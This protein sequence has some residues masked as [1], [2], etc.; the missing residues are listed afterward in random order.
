MGWLNDYRFLV[1]L[2]TNG[3]DECSAVSAS[4]GKS[5][6]EG[7][8][9]GSHLALCCIREMNHVNSCNDIALVTTLLVEIYSANS[10]PFREMQFTVKVVNI[11]CLCVWLVQRITEGCPTTMSR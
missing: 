9:V 2:V 4:L 6:A 8:K 7:P 3:D 5:A 11:V 1:S 10:L